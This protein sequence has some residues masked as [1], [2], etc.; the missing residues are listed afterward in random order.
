MDIFSNKE[1]FTNQGEDYKTYQIPRKKIFQSQ[2][3]NTYVNNNNY[4][5]NNRPYNNNFKNNNNNGNF[6]QK[7]FRKFS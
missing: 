7:N 6:S 4:N 1:N 2:N 3:S 5:N